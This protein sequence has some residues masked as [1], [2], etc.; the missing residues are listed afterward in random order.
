MTSISSPWL[1]LTRG[2]NTVG[3]L[4]QGKKQIKFLLVAINYFTKWVEAEPLAIITEN[5]I[6]KFV[7]R[8]GILRV[9][10]LD[11]G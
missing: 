3:P 10:I 8:F 11:N 1:F 9:I 6:Q 4:P 5:R 2:I 7:C